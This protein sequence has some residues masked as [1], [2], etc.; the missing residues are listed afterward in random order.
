MWLHFEA[1]SGMRWAASNST[2]TG[3]EVWCHVSLPSLCEEPGQ[4]A[5]G[6]GGRFGA[7]ALL[8]GRLRPV[9]GTLD[10]EDQESVG[11][12]ALL[13]IDEHHL[14]SVLVLQWRLSSSPG[15]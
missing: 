14:D 11:A 8:E 12:V 7:D 13:E 5:A 9:P 6:A 4:P 3:H 1:W 10:F 2:L 15:P